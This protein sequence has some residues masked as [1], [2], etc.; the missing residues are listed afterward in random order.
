MNIIAFC[1]FFVHLLNVLMHIYYYNLST[2][3]GIIPTI[4]GIILFVF[5]LYNYC[6]VSG[7]QRAERRY[8]F[9]WKICCLVETLILL[10]TSSAEYILILLYSYV[11]FFEV[12]LWCSLT[13]YVC[14]IID[15][16]GHMGFLALVTFCDKI[17]KKHNNTSVPLNNVNDLSARV[18]TT[19][20]AEEESLNT[21]LG[22]FR[23]KGKF[24]LFYYYLICFI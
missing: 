3:S 4:I 20:G 17:I 7:R 5:S 12:P 16:A 6:L 22:H 19:Q 9:I 11:L 21:M 13:F 2:H 24:W 1:N 10:G 14:A 15:V 23:V 8:I 18:S